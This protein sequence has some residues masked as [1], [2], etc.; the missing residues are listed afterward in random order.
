MVKGECSQRSEGKL[1][2]EGEITNDEGERR[3]REE[4]G[5]FYRYVGV[6]PSVENQS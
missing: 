5:E 3:E 1:T 2:L 4:W 6:T